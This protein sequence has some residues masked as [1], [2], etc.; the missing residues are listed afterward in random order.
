MPCVLHS[1]FHLLY[2]TAVQQLLLG[3]SSTLYIFNVFYGLKSI[4]LWFV[5]C[6]YAPSKCQFNQKHMDL[7]VHERA[8]ARNDRMC[9]PSPEQCFQDMPWNPVSASTRENDELFPISWATVTWRTDS[10]GS[11][12][13]SGWPLTLEWTDHSLCKW[14]APSNSWEAVSTWPEKGEIKNSWGFFMSSMKNGGFYTPLSTWRL[15]KQG[16]NIRVLFHFLIF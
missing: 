13:C 3:F 10:I 1:F 7:C 12:F 8:Q 5:H 6:F 9:F 2:Q 4:L 15:S 16:C 14:T 11:L